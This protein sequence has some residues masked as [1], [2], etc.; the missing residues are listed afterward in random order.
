MQMYHIERAKQ[1][2]K[3]TTSHT[4]VFVNKNCILLHKRLF[5]QAGKQL[6]VHGQHKLTISLHAELLL[7]ENVKRT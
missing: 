7:C 6:P 2:M 5:I 1:H 4:K 3:A